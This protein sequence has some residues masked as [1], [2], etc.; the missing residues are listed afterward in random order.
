MDGGLLYATYATGYNAP[1]LYQLYDATPYYTWDKNYT[2]GLTRGNKNLKAETSKTF[3]V[4]YKQTL[5]NLSLSVAYYTTEVS[6]VIEYVYL[7]NKD[8]AIAELGT[9]FNR[10]D[11]RGDTYINLGTMYTQG[12]ELGVNSK[13][14]EKLNLSANVNLT[15]G[16]LNYRPHTIDTAQTGC[17]HV[18]I[19][20]TGAFVYDKSVD[21]Q[22]LTRR[23][24][25]ANI[26]LTYMPLKR[27][28]LNASIRYVGPRGDVYYE[29]KLGPYGALAT[30]SVEH[31]TLLDL[32]ARVAIY[33]GLSA[34]V[35]VE[36]VTDKKYYEINGFTTRGRGVYVTLRYSL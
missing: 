4:G 1:S 11:Y 5:G 8:V 6:N 34:S 7:W 21:V 26:S 30:V 14:S 12:I 18:Q 3:E 13:I 27:V 24:S 23:P 36:N 22:G 29:S 32:S 17:N 35:R 19:F 16:K 20:N 28:A 9:D 25:T 15:S 2:T 31:Y 33:K 10:D